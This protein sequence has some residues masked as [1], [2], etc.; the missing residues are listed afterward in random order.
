MNVGRLVEEGKAL[1]LNER[2][3]CEKKATQVHDV[4]NA[5]QMKKMVSEVKDELEVMKEKEKVYQ[6]EDVPETDIDDFVRRKLRH[7]AA[8]S[9]SKLLSSSP[10]S[11][12]CIGPSLSTKLNFILSEVSTTY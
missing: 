2:A 7:H 5:A 10:L 11:G 3:R 9:P 8:P 1:D 6:A 12:T 4:T